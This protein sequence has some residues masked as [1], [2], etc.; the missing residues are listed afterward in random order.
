M[1]AGYMEHV[2]KI[3]GN[4]TERFFPKISTIGLKRF[5]SGKNY[6]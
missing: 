4:L 3:Y 1:S 6:W 5:I 2:V